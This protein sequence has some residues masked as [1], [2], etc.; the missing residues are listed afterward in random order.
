MGQQFSQHVSGRKDPAM[1]VSGALVDRS[2]WSDHLSN[3]AL[4]VK[5]NLV[6]EGRLVSVV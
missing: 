2:E 3:L 5:L 6:S 4:S 1:A